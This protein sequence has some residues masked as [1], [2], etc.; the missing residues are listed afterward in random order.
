MDL[1]DFIVVGIGLV[2]IV[3]GLIAKKKGKEEWKEFVIRFAGFAVMAW[4]VIAVV[5]RLG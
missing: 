4:V 2:L 3:I 1:K 5:S